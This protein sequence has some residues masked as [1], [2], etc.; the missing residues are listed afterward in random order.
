MLWLPRDASNNCSCSIQRAKENLTKAQSS[1]AS[2][3]TDIER[4]EAQVL[5]E[6]NEAIV[7]AA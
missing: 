5:I 2:A 6:C 3:T 7:N 4:A 1:L